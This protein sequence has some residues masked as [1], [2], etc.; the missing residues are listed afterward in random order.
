MEQLKKSIIKAAM[1]NEIEFEI[2][3]EKYPYVSQKMGLKKEIASKM[4]NLII[5]LRKTVNI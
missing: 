5:E 2:F 3:K 4:L 1:L